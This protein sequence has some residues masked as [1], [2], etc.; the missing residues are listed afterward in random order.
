MV[1]KIMKKLSKVQAAIILAGV[2]IFLQMT[3]NIAATKVI[4]LWKIVMDAGIIYAL[5]FTWRD[6]IHKQLGKKAA[7]T[8]IILA[9][10]INLLMSIYFVF[11][12]KLPA[13]P[14]WA[15]LG[16]QAAWELLFGLVPRIVLASIFTQVIA[17]LMDTETYQWW[18]NGIGKGKPQWTRVIVSNSVSIPIDSLLFT[19]I[20]FMGVLPWNVL[21]I[22]F[23]SN[24]LT[25][26]VITAVTFWMIYLVPEKPLYDEKAKD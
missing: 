26:A 9:A 6:L 18:T 14:S 22:M 16:G 2:Y 5:T 4:V 25:K 15:A 3:A 13:E 21:I 1:L 20:A 19:L 7:Q 10:V 11:V 17:E 12:I 24:I 8:A 23:L